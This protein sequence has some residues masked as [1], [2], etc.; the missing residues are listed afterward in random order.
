MQYHRKAV[1]S[2][3]WDWGTVDTALYN[4]KFTWRAKAWNCCKFC[5]LESE[6][7]KACP[8]YS[9]YTADVTG[10]MPSKN[11]VYDHTS[12]PSSSAGTQSR[13]VDMYGLTNHTTGNNCY[14][15]HICSMCHNGRL[16]PE[17]LDSLSLTIGHKGDG[18]SGGTWN[19]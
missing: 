16:P 15:A 3:S 13:A 12:R 6:I 2:R 19:H 17:K 11:P 14:Y 18:I 7:E 9:T 4:E 10:G 5:L 1:I 8:L